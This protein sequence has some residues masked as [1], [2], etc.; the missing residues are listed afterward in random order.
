MSRGVTRSKRCAH[1][2]TIYRADRDAY[3]GRKCAKKTL[4]NGIR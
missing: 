1:M 3:K 2:G 4:D